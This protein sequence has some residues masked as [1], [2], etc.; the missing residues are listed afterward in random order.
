[1]KGSLPK[2]FRHKHISDLIV[3]VCGVISSRFAVGKYNGLVSELLATPPCLVN[4][5]VKFSSMKDTQTP[6]G[7]QGELQQEKRLD[8]ERINLHYV[9]IK[10]KELF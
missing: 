10:Q 8:S 3:A 7:E 9:F 1:M 5:M 2:G 6:E 4:H